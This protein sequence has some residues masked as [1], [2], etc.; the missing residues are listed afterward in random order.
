MFSRVMHGPPFRLASN[1]SRAQTAGSCSSGKSQADEPRLGPE[2]EREREPV[3]FPR[4]VLLVEPERSERL[5]LR[6]ELIAGKLEVDEVDDLIP[7]VRKAPILKPNLIL[8]QMRLPG[9][10][11]LELVRRLKQNRTTQT[12]PVI[13][14]GN[15]A[16]AAERVQ[17]F[18]LGAADLLSQPFEGAE[19]IARIRAVLKARY[20]IT[21]LEQQA[22]RDGLTGLANRGV[23]EDQ[24]VRDWDACRRRNAPLTVLIVDLDH[25]KAINDSYGHP[26]GD[27]V[28][29]QVAKMLA[30]SARRSDLVARYGGEEF[31]V[32]APNCPLAAGVALANRFRSLL[33]A[34]TISVDGTP[35]AVTASVGIATADKVTQDS[36]TELFRRADQA[37]YHAKRSGRDAIWVHDRSRADPTVTV[38]PGTALESS[39]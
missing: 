26:A 33:S 29:R 19:L 1:S 23:L 3:D 38:A 5:R 15:F 22:H 4:R 10:S 11:G 25:F 20:T 32:V 8:A 35:I 6:D 37:L 28:L 36:P 13:L 14:Y 31:V 17:A 30:Q 34:R 39:S 16:T 2:R 21:I 27:E 24:L 18:D 12:I 7:A 9:E